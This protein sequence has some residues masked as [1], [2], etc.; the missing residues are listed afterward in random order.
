MVNYHAAGTGLGI[1][2]AT[3]IN[4]AAGLYSARPLTTSFAG[5]NLAHSA[6]ARPLGN[7]RLYYSQVTV[8]PQ[9]SIDCVQRNRNQ[10]EHPTAVL[11]CQFIASVANKRWWSKCVTIYS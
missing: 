8:D 11:I 7:C 6:L 1:C 2:P 5:M 9:K 10:K 4:M 3:T